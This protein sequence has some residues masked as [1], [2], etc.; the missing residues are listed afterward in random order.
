MYQYIPHKIGK[1]MGANVHLKASQTGVF[2]TDSTQ[3]F[4]PANI[5]EA[6]HKVVSIV[7]QTIQGA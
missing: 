6:A 4:T 5:P 1:A 7:F 2:K 3:T